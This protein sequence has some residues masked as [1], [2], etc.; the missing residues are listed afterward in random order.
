MYVRALRESTVAAALGMVFHGSRA[1]EFWFTSKTPRCLGR[2]TAAGA[3]GSHTS[4]PCMA[5][6]MRPQYRQMT[7]IAGFSLSLSMGPVREG[8]RILPGRK[9]SRLQR[10][11]YEQSRFPQGAPLRVL[12][13]DLTMWARREGRVPECPD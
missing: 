9:G 8:H 7:R 11:R 3:A 10:G 2:T 6:I 4:L 5:R 1:G 12:W 13:I